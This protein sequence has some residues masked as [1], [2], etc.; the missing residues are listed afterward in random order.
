MIRI[1]SSLANAGYKII[2][3]GRENSF[4]AP[5][6]SQPFKQK[7]L[8]VFFEKGPSFYLEYNIRLF[9]YLLFKSCDCICAIDLD[10][11][12]PVYF[13]CRL[14]N[15]KRIYD[16][17]EYFSQLKEVITRPAIYKIWHT[18]EKAMV[19][20][21]A[22]GYTVSNSISEEFTRLHGV[23][24]ETIRNMP[25]QTSQTTSLAKNKNIIY[26]GA[27]N[28][29][30]GFEFLIP[31]M[32]KVN[33]VLTIYGD[34]NFMEQARKI[35]DEHNLNDKIIFK[36]KLLPEDLN[37][38]TSEGYVGINL[39]EN[40]GLNQYYSLANKFF[41][42][43]QH[44]VPQVTM[45]FPEYRSLNTQFEVAVLIADLQPSL[46]SAALNK[47]LNDAVLHETLKINCKVA[48]T[49]WNWHNEEKKLIAFYNRIFG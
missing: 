21:F 34:G 5:L 45:D 41:D 1:C 14:R 10:T 28:E 26:Q 3:V 25:L 9:F 32:T 31:A 24:Y 37:K 16:A 36:G 35:T 47:I 38:I 33:A 4:S 39:V 18:I 30:R 8:R 27:V 40:T 44:G 23:K 43:V 13:V 12:V 15:K 29:G 46:I 19:P 42:Y 48:S 49:S 7:R 2:L 22:L 17:H 11:I 20:R 6:C